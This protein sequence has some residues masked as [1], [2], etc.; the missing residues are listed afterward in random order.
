[1]KRRVN[2]TGGPTT[3][4]QSLREFCGWDVSLRVVVWTPNREGWPVSRRAFSAQLDPLQ[5]FARW[6]SAWRVPLGHLDGGRMECNMVEFLAD[7]GWNTVEFVE[8]LMGEVVW[9][10]FVAA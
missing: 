2:T 1:M 6:S 5:C 10:I 8:D 7:R 4:R 3:K 9:V